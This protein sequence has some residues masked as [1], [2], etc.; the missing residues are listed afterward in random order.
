MSSDLEIIKN[1][2]KKDLTD[3]K[4]IPFWSWNDK[5][6]CDE[7][8]RQID[9]MKTNEM[10]G[11]FMHA[12]GGLKTEYLSEEWM[13]CISACVDHGQKNNM[14]AWIYD[15]NGWPSGFAG[16]KLLE[17][18]QNRDKYILSN[19]GEFDKDA[20]VSY[21]LGENSLKRTTDGTLDGEYLNLYIHTS[22][23]TADILN[24]RVVD[25]FI[26]HTH[27]AYKKHFG[28]DFSKKVK[29]F[30]TDEP[31]YY[32]WHT[33]FTEVLCSYFKDKY[34]IDIFDQLG[35][36]FVEKSGY[37]LFRYR[38]WKALQHLMI[39]S[40]AKKIY[41][42]CKNNDVSF[43]GHY[44]QE[45]SLFGQMFCCGGIM[46]FYKYMTMPGIDWLCTPAENE[47]P[48]KQLSSVAAQ[49]GIKQTL[50]E[51]FGCCGWEV[52]PK[53]IK[54]IADFQFV[55]GVNMLCHHLIPYAEYG[56]RKKDHPAHYSP[57]NPWVEREFKDFNLYFTR[58]GYLL[59][60]SEETVDVAVLHPIRSTYISYNRENEKSLEQM[61]N[62]FLEDCRMLS[63]NG[64]AYHFLDETLLSEDGF[65]ESKN[66]SCGKCSYSYL[67]LPH[68]R[69][70]DKTTEILLSK[71]VKNGG[72]LLI[73]GDPP[74]HCEGER[75]EFSYLKSNI[76][77]QDLI[78][79]QNI[80]IQNT[81]TEIYYNYRE[82]NGIKFLFVQNASVEKEY[83]QTFTFRDKI[84]SFKQLDLITLEEKHIPTTVTLE[85]GESML[86]FPDTASKTAEENLIEH[87]FK[88]RNAEVKVSNNYLTVDTVQYSTDGIIYSKTYPCAGLFA[89][90][91]EERYEGDIYLKYKFDVKHIPEK[92]TISVEYC[93]AKEQYLNGK[94]FCFDGVSKKEK[95]LLNA[96]ITNLVQSGINEYV[97]K[98]NWYQSDSVYYALFGEGVTESLKNCL[99]Y[100]TELEPIYISG[101]FGVYPKEKYVE[102]T[103]A[104]LVFGKDFY[105]DKM[106][107]TVT[108]PVTEGFPF[109]AGNMT[110]KQTI[111]LENPNISLRMSGNWQAAYITV[112]GNYVGKLVYNRTL[113][114]SKYAVIGNNTIEVELIISNRNLLGPHHLK[115]DGSTD[116]VSPWCFEMGGT[117]HNGES[118][119]YA[120][121][122]SF[123][124]IDC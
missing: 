48:V 84:Q 109:F 47:I 65:V 89:K 81:D 34:D 120:D 107:V 72:K 70:I 30:F 105:I 38:Y 80:K 117:W 4:P 7:L 36:L 122:Y 18:E 73:L 3:W 61:D 83:T 82:I 46:P 44:V 104:G 9:W 23:S 24:P 51:S 116:F 59:S 33:P 58:L 111:T 29:G 97:V 96:D 91:L 66:I 13:D 19:I 119:S 75:F 62:L 124:L 106:P 121:R 110:L 40:F 50:T 6:D 8:R 101:D 55:N 99:V 103:K 14:N 93:D 27:E 21:L 32:R 67:I 94:S 115:G 54:R 42:W 77:I 37:E 68:I 52:T 78:R 63:K 11:F 60:Q 22:P 87:K 5:L 71:Y 64:I 74:T 112:N 102:S 17:E 1:F 123:L 57:V 26:S 25:K 56:Q 39:E 113:D 76:D 90:L 88:L 15:E 53:D 28:D 92:T 118:D 10:G 114:I 79:A 43:T 31:Q 49:Y 35:L 108:E 20:T 12:R 41:A 86:L 85:A 100:D 95:H 69:C 2:F 98:L 45:D 16:G